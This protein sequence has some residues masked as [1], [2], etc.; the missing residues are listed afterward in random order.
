[1]PIYS[2]NVVEVLLHKRIGGMVFMGRIPVT[3]LPH[4]CGGT[5]TRTESGRGTPGRQ[6]PVQVEPED[7]V[8]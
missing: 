7:A 8:G 5:T 1:M 4:G 6:S 3:N 2:R